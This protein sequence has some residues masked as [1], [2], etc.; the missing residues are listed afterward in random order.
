MNG[1]SIIKLQSYNATF[2][3]VEDRQRKPRTGAIVVQIQIDTRQVKIVLTEKWFPTSYL[4]ENKMFQQ[5]NNP[6]VVCNMYN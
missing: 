3:Q 6:Q 4:A 1:Y 5:K 2:Q